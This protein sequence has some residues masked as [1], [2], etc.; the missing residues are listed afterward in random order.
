[1]ICHSECQSVTGRLKEITDRVASTVTGS[2]E[3]EMGTAGVSTDTGVKD[4]CL[5]PVVCSM[6]A[7]TQEGLGWVAEWQKSLNMSPRHHSPSRI[8]LYQSAPQALSFQFLQ[9]YTWISVSMPL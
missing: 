6:Q 7:L 1:M 3:T 5:A 2:R 4:R 8:E 9:L